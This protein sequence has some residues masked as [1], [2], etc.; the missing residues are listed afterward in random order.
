MLLLVHCTDQVV[1]VVASES[2]FE[3]C[4]L[5]VTFG[6]LVVCAI[7]RSI[8]STRPQL[9]YAIFVSNS[10]SNV[11]YLECSH[12]ARVNNLRAEGKCVNYETFVCLRV[13][14]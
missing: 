8:R 5:S 6:F 14:L 11:G 9:N 2:L 10:L 3:L 13:N 1:S 12:G 4:Q 7:L